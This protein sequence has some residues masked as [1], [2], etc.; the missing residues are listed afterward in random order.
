MSSKVPLEGGALDQ[1]EDVIDNSE[2][3]EEQAKTES[4]KEQDSDM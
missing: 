1:Q 2:G 3:D 4:A